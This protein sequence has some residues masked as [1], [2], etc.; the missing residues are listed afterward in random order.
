M[1]L[2]SLLS[3][4]LSVVLLLSPTLTHAIALPASQPQ[5]SNTKTYE[6]TLSLIADTTNSNSKE[7]T[8]SYTT[9]SPAKNNWVGI[10]PASGGGP[11]EEKY[12]SNS[13]V[14][15]Y[16]PDT[17]SGVVKIDVGSLANG[18][19]IAFLLAKDGYKW[20]SR[21]VYVSLQSNN[22]NNG[23]GFLVETVTLKNGRQGDEYNAKIAGLVTPGYKPRFE[24]LSGDGWVSVSADG[25]IS[26]V[27]DRARDSIVTIRATIP[28]TGQSST[29]KATIPIKR[30]G[31]PL[32]PDLKV[33]TFNLWWGGTYINNYHSKQIKF[34]ISTNVDIIGLQEAHGG[35]VQRLADA[36]GWYFWQP[37]SGDLGIISRYPIVEDYGLVNASGGVRISLDGTDQ[38]V[39]FWNMHLGY[40]PYGPYDFCFDKMS[41]EKVL[42]RE[43]QSGRTPQIVDTLKAMGPQIRQAWNIPVILVGDANAPSHLD[44]TEELRSKNCG[45][46]NIPWPTSTKPAEVGLIDSFRIANPDP[47]EV[48]GI[49][50]SP[51]YPFHNGGT[52]KVEPQDRIDYIYH[53]GGRLQVV[54]SRS[55]VVGRPGVYGSHRDNEWTSDHAVVVTSYKL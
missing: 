24:K 46:A 28:T 9:V 45:Y 47:V 5:V 37:K 20:L 25:I 6:G 10:Y 41:V 14:W 7:L 38:Q 34:I 30:A 55:L 52:G 8:F 29:L 1:L 2:P 26:G 21:P 36:L 42:Q 49:T 40:D 39:N 27:P 3:T 31:S 22:N 35:H 11:V 53:T 48:P 15:K 54:E 17:T 51:I 16:I 12:V 13:L 44:W 19:Y 23:N 43:A 32:V 50:W 4:A 33:M 18:E